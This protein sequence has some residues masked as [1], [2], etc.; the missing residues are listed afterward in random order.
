MAWLWQKIV[1]FNKF[2][3]AAIELQPVLLFLLSR[4]PLQRL[5]G[6]LHVL[7]PVAVERVGE[8]DL[9]GEGGDVLLHAEGEVGH[10]GDEAV[11]VIGERGARLE[12]HIAVLA[13]G[14]VVLEKRERLINIT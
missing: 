12:H 8:A 14:E 10:A 9:C 1:P 6:L 11:E 5:P 2:P 4:E 13:L 7:V 3:L